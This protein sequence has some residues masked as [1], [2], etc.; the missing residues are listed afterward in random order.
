MTNDQENTDSITMR[1]PDRKNVLIVCGGVSGEHEVSLISTKHVLKALSR[2]SYEPTVL[3]IQKS[4]QIEIV[5]D[6]DFDDLSDNPSQVYGLKGEPIL[7][8]PYPSKKSKPGVQL[9]DEFLEIDIA[10]P[11]VHGTGGE[12]GSLQ[13][14][15]ELSQIPYVGC[16]VRSSA[17]AMN[18]SVT[19]RIAKSSGIP[20]VDF[21]EISSLEDLKKTNLSFP[22]FVKPSVGGSSLGI[23]IVNGPQEMDKAV[24]D[25][26]YWCEKI[27]IEPAIEGREI[28][29]AVFDDGRDRIVSPPGEIVVE[30]G[31]Y[32]Y[33]AK[34]VNA[35]A[36]K[37]LAPTV[38]PDDLKERAQSYASQAFSALECFGMARVDFFVTPSGDVLLNEVNTIPGFT[39]I[40]MYPKLMGLAGLNYSELVSRLIDSAPEK[41]F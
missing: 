30:S 36:A 3:V 25:A 38:L 27:M 10:F 2:K 40:S 7:F 24:Q 22:C 23:S 11:L 13:G 18:K 17:N 16:G 41:R 21:V 35:S 9:N 20:V 33:D 4:G 14:F 6:K 5:E 12:D 8:K 29:F 1:S 15:L 31:F 32:D 39:P 34:Y 28:E 37:L 19:K 26:F